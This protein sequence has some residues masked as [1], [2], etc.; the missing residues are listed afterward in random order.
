MHTRS[1][2]LLFFLFVSV[3]GW[4][5]ATP[6]S[7]FLPS[8]VRREKG[9][10][11]AQRRSERTRSPYLRVRGEIGRKE[12]PRAGPVVPGRSEAQNAPKRLVLNAFRKHL[13][14]G[15]GHSF[16]S[17]PS[18]TRK[19]RDRERRS[20]EEAR[21]DLISL[22]RVREEDMGEG[23]AQRRPERTRSLYYA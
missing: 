5:S 11:E 7:P 9:E 3:W 13:G 20:P 1:K 18:I 21:E 23:T 15:V 8:R 19:V 6:F 14:L 16:L 10:E 22:L 4:G 2:R 12:R 17:I